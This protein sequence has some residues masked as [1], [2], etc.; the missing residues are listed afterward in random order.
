MATGQD[1][2]T[3]LKAIVNKGQC[4]I[5]V[6]RTIEDA[7][8][9]MMTTETGVVVFIEEKKPVGVLTERDVV[10]FLHRGISLKSPLSMVKFPPLIATIFC[11]ILL[12]A[13]FT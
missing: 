3:T 5:P 2:L 1:W 12:T 8:E 10:S 13:T 9:L 7:V 6:D 4:S 11:K